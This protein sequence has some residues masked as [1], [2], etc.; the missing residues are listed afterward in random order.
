MHLQ[1]YPLGGQSTPL[2]GWFSPPTCGLQEQT[3]MTR[4]TGPSS[5]PVP[6]QPYSLA[7][8]HLY[9]IY[10]ALG[11]IPSTPEANNKK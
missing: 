8:E 7:V 2:R 1:K 10:K 9:S 11:S 6:H 4:L 5:L 3:Q